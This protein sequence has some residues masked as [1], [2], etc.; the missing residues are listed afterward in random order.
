M[1]EA[2]LQLVEVRRV[3]LRLRAGASGFDTEPDMDVLEPLALPASMVRAAKANL[4]ALLAVRVRDRGME[5][6]FFEDDW[7]VID[8]ADRAVR[9]GEVFAVNW[10]GEACIYQL[11]NRGGQW[12]LNS[13]NPQFGPINIK[14]GHCNIVGRAVIQ[15]TRVLNYRL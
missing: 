2:G 14:S 8:T 11:V 6:M 7:V 5:P 12:Y 13:I 9:N 3:V 4:A 10:N 1:S 15:P